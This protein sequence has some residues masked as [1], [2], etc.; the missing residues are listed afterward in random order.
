VTHDALRGAGSFR[1]VLQAVSACV[2]HG[3]PF[4]FNMTLT[5]HNRG[6]VGALVDLGAGLGALGVRCGHLLS[7]P[8]PA[9]TGLELGPA[10]RRAL[11]VELR[12]LQAS[13]PF[14]VGLA[15]GGYTEDLFPCAALRGEEVSLDW[16]GRLGLCCQLSEFAG[17]EAAVVADLN[18]V[19]LATALA[20]LDVR[21]AAFK[22]EKRRRRAGGDWRDDD[23]FPCW[24]CAKRLGGV[25]WIRERPD[26]PW[27]RA[28]ALSPGPSPAGGGERIEGSDCSFSES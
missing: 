5:S 28:L 2:L 23:G 3:L 9:D 15:P 13:H 26:H 11:D 22:D 27:Y 4:T 12:A 20:A 6:E 16:R 8:G 1:R 19:D 18:R 17:G 14:P 21:R 10:E 7:D 24:Y 25:E